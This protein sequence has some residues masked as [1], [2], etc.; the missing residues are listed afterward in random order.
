MKVVEI[1]IKNLTNK[2]Y[3]K[4]TIETYSHYLEKFLK[5]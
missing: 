4:R 2:N 5:L 1:Y 3:S